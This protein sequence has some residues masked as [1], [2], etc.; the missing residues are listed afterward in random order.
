MNKLKELIKT[1]KAFTIL[2]VENDFT[3]VEK[4]EEIVGLLSSFTKY[5]CQKVCSELNDRG[6][7]QIAKELE[8]YLENIQQTGVHEI[9]LLTTIGA[10]SLKHY[11]NK[12]G[13]PTIADNIISIID[14]EIQQDESNKFKDVFF[15]NGILN[16]ESLADYSILIS[17]ISSISEC[18]FIYRKE[19]PAEDEMSHLL[20]EIASM[21]EATNSDFCLSIIDKLLGKGDERGRELIQE[22]IKAHKGDDKIKH[23]CCLYTS[24][25]REGKLEF[26]EDYFIQ[27]V[28][29]STTEE[30]I[31]NIENVLAQSAYAAVF[32]LL[33]VKTIDSAETTLNLVLKNQKNIKYII[34]K[35]HEEGI[36]AYDA[37][38]YWNDLSIRNQFDAREVKDFGFIARLATFFNK[39]YLADHPGLSQVSKELKELNTYELFDYNINKKHLSIAPGDI[40]KDDNGD[41]YILV[42]QLCDLLLRKESNDR[43]ARI[44]ELLKIE[45]GT[46]QKTKFD[47][48]VSNGKKSIYIDNFYDK[49]VKDYKTIKVDIS[50][51]NIFFAD[52]KVLDLA[53][54][55]EKGL[56]DIDISAELDESIKQVLS[57]NRDIYYETL[58]EDYENIGVLNVRQLAATLSLD[59]VD[60]SKLKFQRDGNVVSHGLQRICRLKGRYFDSL[61]NNYLNNK[62]RIDLNL[63][64]T[65]VETSEIKTLHCQF[66][67]DSSFRK[68]I[69]LDIYTNKKGSYI[70][71]KELLLMLPEEFHEL[72]FYF[73]D[74]IK[75]S[76]KKIAEIITI[77]DKSFELKFRYRL[78]DKKVAEISDNELDYRSLFKDYPG[79]YKEKS[80]HP[81]GNPND[82][83]PFSAKKVNINELISGIIIPDTKEKLAIINGILKIEQIEQ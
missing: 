39:D 29:K 69:E 36:P 22:I 30:T 71:K 19:Y 1:L 74:E 33:R 50:T 44:G 2:I 77:D 75:L 63:I 83:K 21:M 57:A 72:A 58:K 43:N 59:P 3:Y 47:I 24:R 40:W 34:D 65:T 67:N 31:I 46:S 42:G 17:E 4:A 48:V 26:Y 9:S 10:S 13:H 82:A 52:L 76:D 15:N 32:N 66:G 61:Y 14:A 6:F 64:D 11:L 5:R 35:S 60:F 49:L 16:H 53:M 55:N 20:Q 12:I 28:Q 45:F 62:G 79:N 81:V 68:S 37:I 73:D 80:F 18:Q 56:C 54:Y 38:K 8:L 23:I 25:P 51:P 70:L 27:E 7:S 41:Y 78:N